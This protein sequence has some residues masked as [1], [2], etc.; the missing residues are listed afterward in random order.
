MA[1]V[2]KGHVPGAEQGIGRAT[3]CFWAWSIR[4]LRLVICEQHGRLTVT[5]SSGQAGRGRTHPSS[6]Q[7]SSSGP[8]KAL[9]PHEGHSLPY[10]VLP[11]LAGAHCP[12]ALRLVS[13]TYC[14]WRALETWARHTAAPEPATYLP[15]CEGMWG[16]GHG[17]G[18]EALPAEFRATVSLPQLFPPPDCP[19]G[20]LRERQGPSRLLQRTAGQSQKPLGCRQEG[21]GRGRRRG[22]PPSSPCPLPPTSSTTLGSAM[23]EV[24]RALHTMSLV[25]A[26][27]GYLQLGQHLHS[28]PDVH[29]LE[30]PNGYRAGWV[31]EAPARPGPRGS[32]SP[33]GPS[34]WAAHEC[35]CARRQWS[36]SG[37]ARCSPLLQASPPRGPLREDS[38]VPQAWTLHACRKCVLLGRPARGMIVV[39][40][41]TRGQRLH[42]LLL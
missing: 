7:A 5:S 3:H 8:G 30:R 10:C 40:T 19:G 24:H 36:R 15:A 23:R 28:G 17:S 22:R 26:G 12:L 32:S 25:Q 18:G 16:R 35:A 38:A 1:A 4:L 41:R 13:L 2:P 21:G 31:A 14:W 42:R 37:S 29:D 27:P 34:L 39:P 33:R 11:P 6:L 9:V 20:R